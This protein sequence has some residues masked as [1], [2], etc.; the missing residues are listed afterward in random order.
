MG[1]HACVHAA[2]KYLKKA[3]VDGASSCVY[4]LAL[5]LDMTASIHSEE[6]KLEEALIRAG[7]DTHTRW[8]HTCQGAASDAERARQLEDGGRDHRTTDAW[9][10]NL[11]DAMLCQEAH[12]KEQS[13]FL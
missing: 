2:L 9:H 11:A 10:G 6:K 3:S 5:H 4:N 12:S 7:G 13:R 1:W 8:T